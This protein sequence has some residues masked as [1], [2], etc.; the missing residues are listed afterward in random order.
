[1][2]KSQIFTI[3]KPTDDSSL[4]TRFRCDSMKIEI[5]QEIRQLLSNNFDFEASTFSVGPALS[6]FQDTF[7]RN[8]NTPHQQHIFLETRD[9]K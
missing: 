9:V 3:F 7:S 8:K 5:R 1:M 2:E 4:K 6:Q